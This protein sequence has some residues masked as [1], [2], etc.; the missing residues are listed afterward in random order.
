MHTVNMANTLRAGQWRIC[1]HID[2]LCCVFVI[3][4]GDPR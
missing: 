3:Q 1:L 4:H 2:L